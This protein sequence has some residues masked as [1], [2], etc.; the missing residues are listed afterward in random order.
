MR[1]LLRLFRDWRRRRR[2]KREALRVARAQVREI[3]YHRGLILERRDRLE[4]EWMAQRG[5]GPWLQRRNRNRF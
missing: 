2:Q 3:E 1:R 5:R 4:R